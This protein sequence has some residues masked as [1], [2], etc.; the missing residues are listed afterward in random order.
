MFKEKNIRL[1]KIKNELKLFRKFY[2]LLIGFLVLVN[3]TQVFAQN[4]NINLNVKDVTVEELLNTI[5]QKTNYRF[6]YSKQIVDVNRKVSLNAV[7]EKVEKV[8]QKIFDGTDITYQ[9]DRNQVVLRELTTTPKNEKISGI[10]TDEYGMEIVGATVK[11]EG[12][13]IGTITDI[14]GKFSLDAPLDGRL[15]VSFIGYDPLVVSIGGKTSVNIILKE[16]VETLDELVVIGYGTQRR[17]LVTNAISKVKIDES[18]MRRT[19]T[20]PSQ[21]LE[22]RVAGLTVGTTS[23]NLGTGERVSIRGASS[24]SASNQPLYVVDGIPITNSN[25]NIYNFGESMSSLSTLNLTD[26]ESIEVLKDAAS[27]AIYGSRGTNGVVV[28]TT[29][30]GQQGKSDIQLNV[31]TGIS[32][33]AN[34]NKLKFASSDMYVM[35][36]NEGV[37]NYNNQYDLQ[38]G[39]ANY[40]VHIANPFEGLP[41]S[42]WLSY[43][44]QTGHSFNGD[45]SFSGGVNKTN[46]YIG[47][48]ITS[49]EGIIKTN[50]LQKINLKAKISHEVRK[51]LEIGANVSGNYLRNTQVPGANLGT[52]IIARTVEQRPFDRPIKPNGD[53]YLGGTDELM[54]HNPIQILNEQK[55]YF[56]N[57][58]YLGG[59]YA[60]LKLNNKFTWRTSFNS[61]MAYTYDYSYYNENHPYGTGVGRIIEYNRFNK[62]ILVENVGHYNDSFDNFNLGLMVG[63][64]FQKSAT[65]TTLVDGRG[66]PSPAFDVNSVASEIYDASGSLSEF[67][68]ESYFGRATMAYLE[69]YLMTL[70]LRTDGSSKFAPSTRWGWFPSASL[71]WNVS[72]EEFMK[73]TGVD[74]K[75]RVSYGKTGNQDGIS[76][77]AYQSLMSGGKNYG[78][79]SGIAITSFGND[80]LTWETADQY[81]IGLDMELLKGRI[82]I[83]LDAYLKKTNN[84]LYSMPIH[85]TTGVT[86]IMS[87]IGSM[88]NQG[89]EFSINTDFNIGQ[90]NWLAQFNIAT[91]QNKITALLG[92]DLPLSIGANRALQVGKELGA[93]YLFQMEGIYQYDGEVPK[94]FYDLGI[95]A[96]DV[97]WLDADGNNIINDS[98]RQVMGAPTPD[99]F[100]G[101]NNSFKYKNFQLDIFFTYMYGNKVYN[102]RK[103]TTIGRLG[104]RF[105]VLEDYVNN[106]WTGPGSTNKYPRAINSDTNNDRNSDRWLED[107]SFIRLRNATLSY[108]IPQKYLSRLNV[109]SLRLYAQGDNL[110]LLTRY[111]GYDPEVSTESDPRLSGVDLLNVPQPRTIS[112][113]ANISF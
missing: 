24:L 69:K 41:D 35:Q 68:M 10:I 44:T 58:R 81:D 49:M 75:F 74:M 88:R 73:D 103:G 7:N 33:F 77:Y 22:G 32:T 83:I 95:R 90:V 13:S 101:L 59:Y 46:Y 112:F 91:N 93:F 104:A 37:D 56:D 4:A 30:S 50:A 20:S 36:Y 82:N 25:A 92:D 27:A 102:Q 57:Y 64:S 52:T 109:K 61:D 105:A 97:K 76:N 31:N 78:E 110:F 65:N 53:Y 18:N 108:H 89:V 6:L 87:N 48:N 29:K 107:G 111:S 62:N 54:F 39:D 19:T 67:A 28:I 96:G 85:A 26:I 66:F 55:V 34:R 51:W 1:M 3:T 45:L 14:D 113:G 21:L 60:M 100:G 80:E 94:E 99:F 12:S 86:S 23:G 5:E 71:G 17:S 43:I 16:S 84:L 38:V 8:L 15:A 42:D 9:I 79:T 11:L 98:D 106:R 70:T 2:I 63:H 47:G 72:K 40:K